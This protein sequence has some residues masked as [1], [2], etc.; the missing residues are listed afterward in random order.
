MEQLGALTDT[1]EQV[2]A[3]IRQKF[4]DS[5]QHAGIWESLRAFAAA[6]DWQVQNLCS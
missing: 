4:K 5:S 6:V 2:L 1:V 3:E